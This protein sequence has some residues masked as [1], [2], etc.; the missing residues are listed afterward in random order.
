MERF[1]VG[2]IECQVVPDGAGLYGPGGFAV[3]VPENEIRAALTARAVDGG[4]FAFPYNCLLIRSGGR[5]A[6]VDTGMGAEQA[7][8]TGEPGGRLMDSLAASGLTAGQVDLV[9]ISHAHSDHIGGLTV[10]AGGRR[11]PVFARARH[12]FWQAEW[13]FWT[14]EPGLAQV[15]D[16]LAAAARTHLP[17]LHRAG[18]VELVSE[19]TEVL[20]GVRLL[21]A[22]GHTPGHLAVALTSGHDGALYLGDAVLDEAN[23]AHPDWVTAVEWNPRMA[24]ATRTALLEKAIAEH[25]LLIAFHLAA[26][27]YAERATANTTSA[28]WA[29]PCQHPGKRR[30]GRV[31][32][33]GGSREYVLITRPPAA[34]GVP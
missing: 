12:Y 24:V 14:S 23:L 2:S 6:L 4:R 5:I 21:P 16:G 25:R 34:R 7:R 27:G 28:T 19:E 1:A 17:P 22:P 30:G 13:D 32:F 26:R 11:V 10:A 20:P 31:P 29:P 9:I 15:P 8:R 33:T 3:G 18:L